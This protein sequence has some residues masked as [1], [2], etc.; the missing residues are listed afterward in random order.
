M[1]R[2]E[3]AAVAVSGA[4]EEGGCLRSAGWHYHPSISLEMSI[5]NSRPFQHEPS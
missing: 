4:W 1:G 2:H 5:Q 3:A